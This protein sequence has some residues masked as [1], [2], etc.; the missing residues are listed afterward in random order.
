MSAED[1]IRYLIAELRCAQLRAQLAMHDLGAIGL[2]LK[3]GLITP[4]QAL[5]HVEAT[6]GVRFLDHCDT[7]EERERN[8]KVPA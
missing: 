7:H 5:E 8:D 2:A 3:G 4:E 6:D 1:R